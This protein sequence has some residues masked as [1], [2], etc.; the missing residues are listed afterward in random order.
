MTKNGL[1]K[2]VL[3][4]GGVRYRRTILT[5]LDLIASGVRGSIQDS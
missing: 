5:I 2:N 3:D 4:N 1:E